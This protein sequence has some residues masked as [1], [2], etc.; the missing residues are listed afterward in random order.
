MFRTKT[1]RGFAVVEFEDMYGVS[2]SIQKSSLASED[3]VWMGLNEV[4]PKIMAKEL[5]EDLTGWVN[6]PSPEEV[7]LNARMHINKQQA[8]EIIEVLQTFVDT[9]EI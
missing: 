5:R 6:F 3:C 4:V 9:G 1:E 8:K 2:C 7:L